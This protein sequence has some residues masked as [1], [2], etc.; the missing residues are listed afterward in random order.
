MVHPGSVAERR[1]F[2]ESVGVVTDDKEGRAWVAPSHQITEFR[3]V[4]DR[5]VR[6]GSTTLYHANTDLPFSLAAGPAP[7]RDGTARAKA[8]D[9]TPWEGAETAVIERWIQ[10]ETV[11][12]AEI[13][14]GEG[15]PSHALVFDLLLSIGLLGSVLAFAVRVGASYLDQATG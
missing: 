5:P 13:Q 7:T 12:E 3:M 1:R 15:G 14:R 2:K 4:G 6:V 11:Y 8:P 10:S 9:P